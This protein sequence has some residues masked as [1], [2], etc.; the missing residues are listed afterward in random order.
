MEAAWV[1]RAKGHGVTCRS[2]SRERGEALD[3][4]LSFQSFEGVVRL[5]NWGEGRL[6]VQESG[7]GSRTRLSLEREQQL[8]V[9]LWKIVIGNHF[10]ENAEAS[11]LRLELR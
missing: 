9:K 1:L 8:M 3:P 2:A 7:S 10:L 4:G 5:V 6:V 11:T